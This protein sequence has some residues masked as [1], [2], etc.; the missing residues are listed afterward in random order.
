MK[1]RTLGAVIAGGQSSR[2]GSDKALAL[3]EGRAMIEHVVAALRPWVDELVICGRAHGENRFL[4]DYPTTG[5]GPLAGFNAALHYAAANGFGSV[6][7]VPCDTPCIGPEI[8][9]ALRDQAGPACLADCPVI[10]VWPVALAGRL[11]EFALTDPRRSVRGWAML[12]GAAELAIAAPVNVNRAADLA[13]LG[14]RS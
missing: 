5:L 14:D 8:F 10:G 6:I 2:F 3:I 7:T 9:A 4:P 13:L 11:H 1:G 12:A